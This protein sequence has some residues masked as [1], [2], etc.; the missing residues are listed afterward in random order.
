MENMIEKA[1]GE[2]VREQNDKHISD[3]REAVCNMNS[4]LVRLLQRVSDLEAS[5]K[6]LNEVTPVGGN[7]LSA[8]HL[9]S[10][11]DEL[12]R[13]IAEKAESDDLPDLDDLR[14]GVA[15]QVCLRIS[16]ALKN[17]D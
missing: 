5:V 3:I 6:L 8:S 15:D 2:I 1:I 13:Q 17:L 10:R 14:Q 11:I 7:G 9:D 12:E 16:Q 4:V